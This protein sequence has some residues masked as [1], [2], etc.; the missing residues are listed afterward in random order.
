MMPL[1]LSHLSFGDNSAS[2]SVPCGVLQVMRSDLTRVF[3]QTLA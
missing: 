3:D 1:V 2:N